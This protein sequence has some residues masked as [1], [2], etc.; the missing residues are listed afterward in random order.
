MIG[1]NR[2]GLEGEDL[3]SIRNISRDGRVVGCYGNMKLLGV[4]VFCNRTCICLVIGRKFSVVFILTLL[5]SV[6]FIA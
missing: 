1:M 4:E 3:G 2:R 6:I 5:L